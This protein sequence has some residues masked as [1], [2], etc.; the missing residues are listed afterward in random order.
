MNGAI[1]PAA[2]KQRGVRSI[3]NGIDVESD[4]VALRDLQSVADLV[5][6]HFRAKPPRL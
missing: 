5:N 4:D 2:A 1:H 6:A 3:D